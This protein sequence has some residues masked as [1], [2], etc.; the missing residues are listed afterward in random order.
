MAKTTG[1]PPLTLVGSGFAPI[2]PPRKLGEFGMSL[3]NRVQAEYRVEDCG[4]LE[5]LCLACAALDRAEALAAC[6]AADGEVVHTRSGL[7]KAHPAIRDE[8]AARAFVV[9]TLERLGINVEAIKPHG[10]PAGSW[11]PPR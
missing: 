6:I 3:W 1:T 5:I 11:T 9:R 10:R 2:S 7:P 8:L 4:G